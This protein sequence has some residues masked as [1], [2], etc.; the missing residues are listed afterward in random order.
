[1]ISHQEKAL[2][3]CDS[4]IGVT[5]E[6]YLKTFDQPE[7]DDDQ[8]DIN[9]DAKTSSKYLSAVTFSLNLSKYYE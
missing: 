5:Q 2:A 4:L 8:K 1:M 7:L 3:K 9:F 6:E